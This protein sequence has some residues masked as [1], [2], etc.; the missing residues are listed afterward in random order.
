MKT[1]CCSI[2][3]TD[4]EYLDNTLS[5][6][7][8]GELHAG[9]ILGHE[10]CGEVVEADAGGEGWA[11][12]DRATTSGVRTLCGECYFCRRRLYHLCL[13]KDHVRAIYTEVIPGGYGHRNGALAEYVIR[14]PSQV[15]KLPESV[16]DAEGALV[17]PLSVG[18]GGVEA[19]EIGPGD[20]AVVI[21]A[22]KI[23]LGAMSVAKVAGASLVIGVDLHPHRL[24]KA[25][26]MGA[27][28]VLDPGDEPSC[29][30]MSGALR[31]QRSCG[32]MASRS[33]SG[34]AREE[35]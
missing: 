17:E 14:R 2:C 27:D 8:G 12:G 22:G 15:L 10:F 11:V 7:Q 4:L 23:G 29:R 19:A 21:G 24:D 31:P 35:P 33:G 16:S 5:Y 26:E 20:T 30:G 1:K 13:G 32:K 9:A 3:G 34:S 28:V 6:R 25:R 18:V